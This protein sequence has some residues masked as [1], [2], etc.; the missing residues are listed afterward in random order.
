MKLIVLNLQGGVV[1]EPL[2]E[3]IKKVSS[4]TD[5][6]C[7]QEV[8]FG[9]KPDFTPRHK[10]RINLYS[11]LK[12]LLPEFTSYE[13]ISISGH[14]Q[15]E[16]IDF[17]AGQA[18]F[19]RKS[20]AVKNHGGLQ[21]Y[22]KVPELTN[23]GGRMTGN[24]QWIDLKIG[25]QQVIIGNLHGLW[26][27]GTLKIDTPER[28]LQSDRIK[29][30]FDSKNGKKIICGDFNIIPD[31]KSME[32]LEQ[33]MVNLIT[34]Y[35]ITSTRSSFYLKSS[36][37]LADYILVSPDIKVVDFKVLPDEVSDH[38]PLYLEFE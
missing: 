13:N 3:L 25:G 20:I 21:C 4:E 36:I 26:Q 14:F 28:F 6:F 16:P 30:F 18:I 19:V 2:K 32:I 12:A 8:M 24:M 33:G 31:G 37:K 10:A 35:N 38:L 22:D 15:K 23:L 29:K 1:Y 5:I 34:K 17:G 7:F 9:D 27:K 11:E